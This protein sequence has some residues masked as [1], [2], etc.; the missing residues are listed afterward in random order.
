MTYPMLSPSILGITRCITNSISIGIPYHDIL[1]LL[2]QIV[3]IT[4][5]WWLNDNL[6]IRMRW[7]LLSLARIFSLGL[8]FTRP[9]LLI[10]MGVKSL[11]FGTLGEQGLLVFCI[12]FERSFCTFPCLRINRLVSATGASQL[13]TRLI[14]WSASWI[15]KC[16]LLSLFF[17]MGCYCDGD[18]RLFLSEVAIQLCLDYVSLLLMEL[19]SEETRL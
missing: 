12:H 2:L 11:I 8:A 18:E 9:R 1:N 13:K 6:A 4:L 15:W 3:G 7:T 17:A 5:G 16:M 14:I 10:T 19:G